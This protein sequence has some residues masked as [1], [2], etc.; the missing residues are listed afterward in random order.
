MLDKKP[1][2]FFTRECCK[3][4]SYVGARANWIS[5]WKKNLV[6]VIEYIANIAPVE[7]SDMNIFSLREC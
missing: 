1:M 2:K 4:V 3:C 5:V 6:R 7:K